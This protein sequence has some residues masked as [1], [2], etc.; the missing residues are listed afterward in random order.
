MS[1]VSVLKTKAAGPKAINQGVRRQNHV[2]T[3]CELISLLSF[4]EADNERLWQ[5]VL[6]LSLETVALRRALK[7]V[8]KS[9]RVA[10]ARPKKQ[11]SSRPDVTSSAPQVQA[12]KVARLVL[13]ST[14]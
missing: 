11:A 8:E 5:A 13:A 9:R 6:E 12:A 4:L 3:E 14:P 1:P 10:A 7:K 2:E